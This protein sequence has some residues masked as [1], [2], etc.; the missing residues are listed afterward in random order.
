[1]RAAI[2]LSMLLFPLTGICGDLV[3]TVEVL[4]KG[5]RRPLSSFAHAVVYIKNI[6]LAQ[7]QDP[8]L[9]IQKGKAFEPRLLVVVKGQE[10]HFTNADP[11]KHNVFS[12]DEGLSFD[13]GHYP[14]GEH[15][16]VNF[17]QTGAYKV[18]CNI[19]QA[20]VQDV[21]VVENR[22]FSVTDDAG[23]FH[24][25]GVPPGTYEL[26]AW[27]IFGGNQSRTVVVDESDLTVDFT[28]ES[29]KRVREIVS[30]PNKDGRDYDQGDGY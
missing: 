10:V 18:Y 19:H 22:F 14:Q 29:T 23:R 28:L 9:S 5:G 8:A 25:E 27:H 17:N 15:R 11:I 30:H 16:S 6:Q 12:R 21:V 20:M 4:K 26:V 13:L 7:P 3:G 1:M 24:I 2:G